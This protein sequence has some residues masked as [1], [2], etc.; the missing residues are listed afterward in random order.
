MVATP[1]TLW[2]T[3]TRKCF[4]YSWPDQLRQHVLPQ[5]RAAGFL[6]DLGD[7]STDIDNFGGVALGRDVE[8]EALDV[9]A[10]HDELLSPTGVVGVQEES[11]GA[12]QFQERPLN[13]V[14]GEGAT[15]H[16]VVHL[17]RTCDRVLVGGVS[18]DRACQSA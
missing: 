9:G 18:C 3:M 17:A 7:G 13:G 4:G 10:W 15:L 6:A 11:A 8:K 12:R 16:A 5:R 1:Y 14:G 2:Y